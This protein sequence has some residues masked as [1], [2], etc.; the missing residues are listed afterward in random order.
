MVF[1]ANYTTAPGGGMNNEVT[2]QPRETNPFKTE[3]QTYS[4]HDSHANSSTNNS[5]F[6]EEQVEEEEDLVGV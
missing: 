6:R 3:T 5:N 1:S 4:T 2:A